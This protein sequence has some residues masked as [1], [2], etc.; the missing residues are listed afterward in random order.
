MIEGIRA[1]VEPTQVGLGPDAFV[2]A[3]LR[4]HSAT[5]DGAFGRALAD[6]PNVV[7]AD[8]VAGAED[9]LLHVVAADAAELHRTLLALKRAGAGRV[10]TMLRL[11]T[12]KPASPY[13]VPH[14]G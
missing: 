3:T 7:R 12:A 2:L 9:V 13:P 14:R 10:R 11:R 5:A 6:M 1:V 4:D 8:S